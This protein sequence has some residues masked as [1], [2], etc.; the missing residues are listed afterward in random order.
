MKRAQSALHLR[1]LLF[2]ILETNIQNNSPRISLARASQL[3]GYHQD[4]LGQLCRLGKLD[5]VKI[6]RNWFTSPEALNGLSASINSAS[7]VSNEAVEEIAEEIEEEMPQA[8]LIVSQPV[9]AEN[10]TISE[11]DGMPIAIRAMPVQIRNTNSVQGILTNLRI[12]SLQQEVIELRKLLFRLM[13]EVK[14]HTSILQTRETVNRVQDS[15]KHSYVSN[16]DFTTPEQQSQRARMFAEREERSD[17]QQ[18]VIWQKP[19]RAN[20]VLV[21]WTAAAAAIVAVSFISIGVATSTF[22]GQEQP[23][24][25]LYYRELPKLDNQPE[26]AGASFQ[27]TNVL[28][29]DSSGELAPIMIR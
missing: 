29:T 19:K 14:S 10:I 1:V 22:F 5:A 21:N 3:T 17:T 18:P 23:V 20:Y 15:L 24:A 6:G 25:S 11:V 2:M 9:I 26:V 8:E 28:P 16:F 13:E 12:E 4:Y 27:E 7:S